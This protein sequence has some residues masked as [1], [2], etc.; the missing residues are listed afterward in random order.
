[1]IAEPLRLP[2]HGH[3]EGSGLFLQGL[4]SPGCFQVSIVVFVQAAERSAARDAK[5]GQSRT[6]LGHEKNVEDPPANPGLDTGGVMGREHAHANRGRECR[7]TGW[8]CPCRDRC[9]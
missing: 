9:G 4:T 6:V 5:D 8:P 3:D 1:M 7:G 2:F